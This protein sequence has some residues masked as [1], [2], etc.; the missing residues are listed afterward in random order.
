MHSYNVDEVETYVL[1]RNCTF[2]YKS[3]DCTCHGWMW[4]VTNGECIYNPL[5]IPDFKDGPG[6]SPA[7]SGA[8][9][10]QYNQSY[11]AQ[12]VLITV[13]VCITTISFALGLALV[14]MLVRRR[15]ARQ[16]MENEMNANRPQGLTSEE[17]DDICAEEFHSGAN[18]EFD[19]SLC[20]ICL[21]EFNEGDSLRV[22]SCRHRFHVSCIDVW[23]LRNS[24]C[25]LCKS[26]QKDATSP[27]SSPRRF[28]GSLWNRQ[29]RISAS[30]EEASESSDGR[31]VS[32][33]RGLQSSRESPSI[34]MTALDSSAGERGRDGVGREEREDN[35]SSIHS[36]GEDSGEDDRS[37]EAHVQV[38]ITT[39]VLT[40][41]L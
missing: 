28:F 39:S 41:N 16:R 19:D 7:P 24:K 10:S 30:P 9:S 13:I 17:I 18:H 31:L 4:D 22:L 38:R 32:Q 8:Y 14:I 25:P 26:E 6:P 36:G 20:S 34:E 5:D 2:A 1:V 15:F 12:I 33:I 35:R 3:N 29:D 21:G 40:D 27:S 11:V 37:S 23:L